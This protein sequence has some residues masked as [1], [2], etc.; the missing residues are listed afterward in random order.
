MYRH[1]RLAGWIMLFTSLFDHAWLLEKLRGPVPKRA[2]K[3]AS[4]LNLARHA[5]AAADLRLWSS[6]LSM[7][8][9]HVI[10]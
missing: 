5:V 9:T 7:S 3:E 1:Y 6:V 10:L 4:C 2:A 8:H